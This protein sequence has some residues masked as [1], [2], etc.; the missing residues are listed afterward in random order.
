MFVI[1]GWIHMILFLSVLYEA[2]NIEKCKW[3][4]HNHNNNSNNKNIQTNKE[5]GKKNEIAHNLTGITKRKKKKSAERFNEQ[6]NSKKYIRYEHNIEIIIS[7]HRIKFCMQALLH[8]WMK[9]K[10]DDNF[11][12]RYILDDFSLFQF[13]LGHII[14]LYVIDLAQRVFF[15]E[16]S[17]L[18]LYYTRCRTVYASLTHSVYVCLRW[19]WYD[20]R[21]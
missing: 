2:E 10:A 19:H 20:M 14:C 1:R 9:E 4:D 3:Y 16:N 13:I 5:K 18:L 7:K 21:I 6:K 11:N 15:P 17:D 12:T 8:A